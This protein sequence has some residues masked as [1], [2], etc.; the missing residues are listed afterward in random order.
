VTQNPVVAPAQSMLTKPATAAVLDH[1][2]WAVMWRIETA[3]LSA[4]FRVR[5][6][7]AACV[8]LP[9]LYGLGESTQSGVPAD[10]IF[11][12]WIHESGFALS[13]LILGFCSQYGL[14]LLIVA[15]AGG[16]FAEE[17]RLHVWSLLLTRSRSRQQVLAGKFLAIATYSTLVTVL[18]G[19]S[20][21]LTG[22]AVVGTQP[23]VSLDGTVLSAST[24]W[25]ATAESWAT[26]LPPVFALM[27]IAVFVSV[28][29]RNSWAGVVVPL[30]VVFAFN[31]VS[32][33]SAVDPIRPFL[34]TTGFNAWHGLVRT[35][36]YTGQIWTAVLVSAAWVLVC[37]GAASL[38]FLRRD[39]VDS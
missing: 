15:V 19:L 33:L 24:A 26:M 36:V 22:A 13:L 11:G 9:V 23:L 39:V 5:V 31:L 2:G 28:I 17:D 7:V 32:I 37:L 25:V 34:P 16:I 1:R 12:R 6:A 35:S 27:A 29:S 30:V 8:A 18:L 3:K 20:A 38:V 14:P 10:T 4:Q 21:T